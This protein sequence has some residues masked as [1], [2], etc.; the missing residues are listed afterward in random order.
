[1]NALGGYIYI[2][3]VGLTCIIILLLVKEAKKRIGEI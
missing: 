1:M 3:I 2:M